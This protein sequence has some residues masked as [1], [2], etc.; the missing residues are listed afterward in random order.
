[1]KNY[2]LIMQI[3]DKSEEKNVPVDVA[4]DMLAVDGDR[5]ALKEAYEILDKN[6]KAI[7][8]LRNADNTEE[9][10]TICMLS[11]SGETE[12]V[13]DHIQKLIDDGIIEE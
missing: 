8:S 1:M 5:D 4:Y 13:K 10:E 6:Y 2:E 11:E 12:A 9:I 3:L 7:T